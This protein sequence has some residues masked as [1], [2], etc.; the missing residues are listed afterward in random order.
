MNVKGPTSFQ[1]LLTYNGYLNTTYMRACISR[2]LFEK[3]Q[4]WEKIIMDAATNYSPSNLRNHFAVMLNICELSEPSKISQEYK[5]KF[6]EYIYRNETQSWIQFKIYWKSLFFMR[7]IIC[8]LSEPSKISQEYKEKFS[9][10]I[11]RNETQA[12][13]QFKIYWK[14]LFFMRT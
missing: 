2:G 14:S 4:Q 9:E 1:H 7:T 11:Y 8:E 5:E 3:N 13:I 6:S 10:Y 12:W